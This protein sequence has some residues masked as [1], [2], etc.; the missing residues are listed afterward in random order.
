[1]GDAGVKLVIH[2]MSDDDWILAVRAA[3]RCLP[4]ATP[5]Y[6]CG[7]GFEDGEYFSVYVTPAGVM[8]VRAVADV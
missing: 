4:D 1:M 7:V 6:I 5:G 3:K 8:H 2:E